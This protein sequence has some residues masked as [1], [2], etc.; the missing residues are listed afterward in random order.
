[1]IV[2]SESPALS[3]AL[4]SPAQAT[5]LSA[6]E[7]YRVLCDND[8]T[9]A[10]FSRDWWLDATA[11]PRGWDVAVVEKNGAIVATLPYSIRQRFGFRLIGQPLLTPA[12]GPWFAPFNG[13]SAA[14]LSHQR[15][16]MASLI[17][18]LPKYDQFSQTWNTKITN[19]LPFYW[20]GYAQSTLYTYTI[21]LT[22]G[23]DVLAGFTSNMR[24]KLRKA[25][26]M[27]TVI[28]NCA[29]VP[30]FELNRKTFSRQHLA[31]PY[32]FQYVQQCDTA[33]AARDCRKIFAAI[34]A[35][36]QYDS[37]LYLVWDEEVAYLHMAGQDPALRQSGAGILL[38]YEAIEFA[39]KKGLKVFD[40]SGSMIEEV[41]IVRRSC[42]GTQTPYFHITK[43]CSRLLR[44]WQACRS[45]DRSA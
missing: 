20:H 43:S 26:K 28:D 31:I 15:E 44:I 5:S 21:A 6:K 29:L 3:H 2:T 30:F 32:S 37:A 25:Q 1:M 12:L 39:L 16:C 35:S 17:A 7:K 10:L 23:M 22:P 45:T 41:E 34:D 40:F 8:R 13:R 4:L 14:L 19:W 36:G 27:V 11:G 33:L 9:I 38:I 18:Q 42:G 24:N